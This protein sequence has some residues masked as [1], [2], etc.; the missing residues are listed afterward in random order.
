ML[1]RRRAVQFD[2]LLSVLLLS[3]FRLPAQDPLRTLPK[4]YWVEYENAWVCVVHVHYAPKQKL[5]QHDHPKTP[6]LYVYLADAGPVRFQH[7]GANAYALNRSAV[8]TGA[9]RLNPGV[10]EEHEVENISETA[11]DFLRVEFKTIPFH[12]TSLRGHFA[13][14]AP[15]FWN[16]PTSQAVAFEDGNIRLVRFGYQPGAKG[17]LPDSAGREAIDVLVRGQ[18][19]QV[20]QAV[21]TVHAGE[22]WTVLS[23]GRVLENKG[24]ETVEIFRVE[25]KKSIEKRSSS[26]K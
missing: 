9:F 24:S 2:A 15:E 22:T 12:Q 6:T 14:A 16:S 23:P 18:S 8:K 3:G 21:R 11:S 19:L 13:P 17:L 1:L 20:G 4:N 25:R 7:T 26:W 5:P 10:I